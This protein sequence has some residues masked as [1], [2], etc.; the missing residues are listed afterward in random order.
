MILKR[1]KINL[2]WL[3]PSMFGDNGCVSGAVLKLTVI[4]GWYVLHKL[5]QGFYWFARYFE[6]VRHA[7]KSNWLKC[8]DTSWMFGTPGR[9]YLHRGD[10]QS[11]SQLISTWN[12]SLVFTFNGYLIPQLIN[13]WP[14]D[15][16]IYEP[17][18]F[19]MCANKKCLIDSIYTPAD[20]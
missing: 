5:A 20:F 18:K 8:P 13:I 11:M 1:L 16:K 6:L 12:A 3:K 7:I 10:K 2:E 19:K 14:C 4:V 17:N 9:G 15:W